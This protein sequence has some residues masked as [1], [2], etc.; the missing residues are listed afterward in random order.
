MAEQWAKS[1]C[2][3][4]AWSFKVIINSLLSKEIQICWW[5]ILH[6]PHRIPISFSV[7]TAA[8]VHRGQVAKKSS[9]L[10]CWLGGISSCCGTCTLHCL[11]PTCFRFR[12]LDVPAVLGGRKETYAV[13]GFVRQSHAW[14]LFHFCLFVT[15]TG[16]S[17]PPCLWGIHGR[18]NKSCE[19]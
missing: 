2:W 8:I 9:A 6:F 16:Q 7:L 1:S 17:L 12:L 18:R 11:C 10:F 14:A 5:E 13:A 3:E 15:F 4:H 19:K